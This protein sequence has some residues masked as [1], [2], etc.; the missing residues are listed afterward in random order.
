LV[1]EYNPKSAA[2]FLTA[3]TVC[4]P[5]FCAEVVDKYG[6]TDKYTAALSLGSVMQEMIKI[7]N[8]D[9]N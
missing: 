2:E 9:V 8:S 7:L 6:P 5:E 3:N 4:I 1:N